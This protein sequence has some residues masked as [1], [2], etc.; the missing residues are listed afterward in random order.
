MKILVL[1][2]GA[3]GTAAAY[4]LARDGHEVTVV[5]RHAAPA[6][7]TSYANAG[8]VSPGDATAWASP[9]AL[10]TF[11]RGM[12]NHDLG[13]KVRLG[14]DAYLL[15]WSLRFLRQCTPAAKR[16]NTLSKLRLALY[17][18][19]SINA[20]TE[21][22]GIA[23]DDRR[24]GILY[25]Y[26]SRESLDAALPNYRYLADHGL[27]IEIVDAE[28]AAEI[29]PGLSAGRGQF[30]GAVYSPTDQ[31]GDSRLFVTRLAD[32][33]AEK[34]GV[35]FR[36][37]TTVEGLDIEGDGVR[38]V[39]TDAGPLA[40]DIVVIAMGPE[41]GLLGRR[42][43]LD[44]PVYPVKGYAATIPLEDEARGPTMGGADEDRYVAYSRLGNRLRLSCTAEFTGF[45]RSFQPANF[46]AMF[47]TAREIFPGAFDEAR[48]E[49]WAGL[50]PMMPSSVPVLGRARYRNLYL[51]T[52]HGHLGWTM[53]AGSGR[54]L[55]DLVAGRPPEIDTTG[56][57]Y[58]K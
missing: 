32:H 35:E 10:R 19:D 29:D 9:E 5:E 36:F 53:A 51:D 49:L 24:K 55:A 43:G 23:Y 39:R 42:H 17:S 56:L 1:G 14:R 2:A 18:R 34:F 12:F 33:T 6:S 57:L 25:L 38:A 4:Y 37:G 7:G 48:A 22:T 50:R 45:D 44:L 54:L 26:R 8:L 30:A 21:E 3:V 11:V 16:A 15:A 20:L 40:A 28:R 13:I 27:P 46:A 58:G 31:T 52:G 41:S 47:R